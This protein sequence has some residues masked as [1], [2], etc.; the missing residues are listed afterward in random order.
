VYFR[1]VFWRLVLELYILR[2]LEEEGLI[3]RKIKKR[4]LRSERN[5]IV[6]AKEAFLKGSQRV[7]L[8]D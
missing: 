6:F 5:A 2:D 1:K 4:E 7:S 3:A 8:V